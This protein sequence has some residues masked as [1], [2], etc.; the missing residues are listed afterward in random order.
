MVKLSVL[1]AVPLGVVTLIKPDPALIG[2]V[3]VICV[4][5]STLKAALA[6]LKVTADAKAKLVP[7]MTTVL[8]TVPLVGENAKMAGGGLVCPS[9]LLRKAEATSAGSAVK[10]VRPVST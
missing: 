2:T 3:A 8:E 9:T 6:P 1:M 4:P 10:N 7:V 5:E